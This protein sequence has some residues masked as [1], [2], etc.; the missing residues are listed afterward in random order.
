[1]QRNV[2]VWCFYANQLPDLVGTGYTLEEAQAICRDPET[3]STTA[4]KP[5]PKAN[6]QPWFYGYHIK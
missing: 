3:S 5:N 6:G 2:E 4:T 1:M